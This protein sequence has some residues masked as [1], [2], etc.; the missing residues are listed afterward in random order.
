MTFNPKMLALAREAVGLTQGV[1]AQQAGV[2]QALISKIEHGLEEPSNALL[3]RM[4]AVCDVPARFFYQTDEVYGES[5]VDFFHKKRKTLPAKPLRKANALANVVR[6]EAQRMLEPLEFDAATLPVF[7]RDRYTPDEAAQA[8]RAYWRVPAGPLPNLIALIEATA[9]PV[10]AMDLGHEKLYAI[11]MPGIDIHVIVLNS[12]LPASAQRFALAHELGHLVMHNH[13]MPGME[14]E[15]EA[16]AFASALLMPRDDIRPEL[17][18]LRFRDLGTLKN[19]W[20]ASM[21]ALIK[22]A[23]SL[24]AISDRQYRTFNIQLNGLPGGR[25]NEPG[26]FEPEHP[27]FMGH[28]LEHYQRENEYSIDNIIEAMI[29]TRG[30]FEERYL[31]VHKR[32]LRSVGSDGM[33]ARKVSF[34]NLAAFRAAC[35]SFPPA[36]QLGDC[37]EATIRL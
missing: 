26:E 21:A 5:I 11:S 3:E 20:R 22:R 19:R 1:L 16:Q 32:R 8:V 2:S 30:C 34:G 28:V 10:F 36:S 27:R 12:A 25:K 23:H 7:S 4:G 29:I 14:M 18:G 37:A 15:E 33:P 17:R 24:G 13:T 35:A 9:N 6:L 31:G